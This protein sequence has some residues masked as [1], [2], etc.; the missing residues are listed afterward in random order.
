MRQKFNSLPAL[1]KV[2]MVIF[3]FFIWQFFPLELLAQSETEAIA[4]TEKRLKTQRAGMYVLGS[5][6]IGNMAVSGLRYFQTDGSQQRFHQMNVFWNT[7]N[8]TLAGSGLYT[9]LT[10]DPLSLS[11][12]DSYTQSQSLQKLLLFNAGLD[13]GYMA[14]GF[15]MMER[16]RR[17]GQRAD[18]LKGYGQSVIMQGAFLFLFDLVLYAALARQNSIMIE[19]LSSLSSSENGIGLRWMF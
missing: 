4:W 3:C 18:L 8:I 7:V 11:A 2:Q 13:V 6:A 15:Y 12:I 9:A 10:I 14:A 16:S 17:G 5:W 19:L 1:S